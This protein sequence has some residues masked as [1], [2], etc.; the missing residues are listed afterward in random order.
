M[1]QQLLYKALFHASAGRAH[2]LSELLSRPFAAGNAPKDDVP[3]EE[4]LRRLDG[5]QSSD[6]HFKS[7]LGRIARTIEHEFLVPLSAQDRLKLETVYTAFRRGGLDLAFRASAAPWGG[8]HGVFPTLKEL[9]LE[10]DLEGG[11]GNFLATA[12][13]YRAVRDLHLANRIIPVVGDFAGPKALSGIGSYLEQNGYAVRVFYTSNVEQFL[14][15]NRVFSRFVENV[16]TLPV[17]DRSILI[18]SV[19]AR[20]FFHPANIP[21]HRLTTVLQLVS[22][23]LRDFDAGEYV[24]YQ[25]MVTTNYIAGQ[26][27]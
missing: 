3:I 10:C 1:I 25:T 24:D 27:P 6:E 11:R 26:R 16:R 17:D 19:P 4:L 15:R 8:G 14:F 18:R 7:N 20:G 13:G 22:V 21:G 5:L 9:I 23:F 12:E 2:F